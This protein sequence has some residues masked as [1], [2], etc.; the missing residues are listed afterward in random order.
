MVGYLAGNL[1]LIS[2][3]G[4]IS[5]PPLVSGHSGIIKV[6][7]PI[8]SLRKGTIISATTFGNADAGDI[9]INAD[10]IELMGRSPNSVGSST[11]VSFT[12]GNGNAGNIT[13]NT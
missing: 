11:I 12:L 6:S 9:N 4:T 5:F 13:I 2:A 3:I 10:R 1:E 8:L 7:T